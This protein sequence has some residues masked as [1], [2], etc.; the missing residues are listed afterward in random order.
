[1]EYNTLPYHLLYITF[2]FPSPLMLENILRLAL[3]NSE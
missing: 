1:M 2:F 3:A